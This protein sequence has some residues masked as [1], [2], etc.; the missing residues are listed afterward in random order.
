VEVLDVGEVVAGVEELL[1]RSLGG[2]VALAV[3]PTLETHRVVADRSQLEQVLVNL[4]VNARDAMPRGGTVEVS[5]H[6]VRS[7]E[8]AGLGATLSGGPFVCLSV[9]D[10]GDGMPEEVQARAF[11]PFF[12]T[13]PTGQ[14]TGLGLATVYGIV[15]AL[16]GAVRIDSEVGRGTSVRCYLPATSAPVGTGD[17]VPTIDV[18]DGRQRTVLVVEDELAVRTLT[19]RLLSRAGFRVLSAPDGRAAMAI[20][21][22][23]QV[24]DLVLTD[25]VMPGMNGRELGELVRLARP[26]T[27][28]LFMS[29]HTAGLLDGDRRGEADPGVLAKPFSSADLLRAVA[30]AMDGARLQH[31]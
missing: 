22:V 28:V 18:T 24:I 6:H 11:E 12:T 9:S 1:R 20:V 19:E 3:M 15:T 8:E 21:E 14:G 25:V 13:K 7:A 30:R 2:H 23:E 10:D 31:D 26:H 27:P 4:A 16:G 29:G 5:L 17:T